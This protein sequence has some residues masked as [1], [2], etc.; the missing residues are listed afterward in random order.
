M[1]FFLY[2]KHG[3]NNVFIT[4]VLILKKHLCVLFR[5]ETGAVCVFLLSCGFNLYIILHLAY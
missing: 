2:C 4:V 3:S 1:N 5:Y